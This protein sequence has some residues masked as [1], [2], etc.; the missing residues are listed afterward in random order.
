[1][2]AVT[3]EAARQAAAIA[4]ENVIRLSMNSYKVQ[5]AKKLVEQ[6]IMAAV[7]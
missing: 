3:E 1:M 2:K 5:I 7:S 6:S 4:V